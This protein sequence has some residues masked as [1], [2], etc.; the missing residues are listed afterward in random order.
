MLHPAP[1]L[2]NLKRGKQFKI[3]QGTIIPPIAAE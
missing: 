3:I 2:G 1:I